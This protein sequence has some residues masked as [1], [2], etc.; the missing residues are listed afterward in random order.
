MLLSYCTL[1]KIG[2]GYFGELTLIQQIHQ[3][4]LVPKF[5][6]VWYLCIYLV[7]VL[8]KTLTLYSAVLEY[9]SSIQLD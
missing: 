8:S 7:S 9:V 1:A 2:Q 4:F 6:I 3:F 5:C